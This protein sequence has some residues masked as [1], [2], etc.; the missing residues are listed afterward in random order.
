MFRFATIVANSHN[1]SDLPMNKL[2]ELF[3]VNHFIVCQGNSIIDTSAPQY[4]KHPIRCSES[5]C[6]PVFAKIKCPI[7][8][9]QGSQFLY[10][11]GKD[12]NA[13]SLYTGM[14]FLVG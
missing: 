10:A 8:N 7:T 9:T 12:G 4:G 3:N 2:S 13:A 11:H 5:A 6:H 14:L 1:A